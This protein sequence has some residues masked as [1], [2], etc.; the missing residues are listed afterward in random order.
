MAS[1]AKEKEQ[2]VKVGRYVVNLTNLD[3]IWFPESNISKGDI[4][5]YYRQIAPIMLSYIGDR[6]LT[7]KRF[8]EGIAKEGFFHKDAPTYF[9][10]W[11]KREA[12]KRSDGQIVNFVVCINEATLV[13]IAN[14]GCITPHIGLSRIDKL[15]Y[16]DKM[17]FDLDPS[18]D[19][20]SVVQD[21]AKALK[22]IF[23]ELQLPSFVMTTGS[24]GL[25]IVVPL[26][27]LYTFKRIRSFAKQI[28]QLLIARNSALF[29]M[30]IRKNKRNKKIFIDILR[31]ASRQTVVAPYAVRPLSTAPIA[32]PITW[33]E[34]Q[35]NRLSP[36]MYTIRT[37]FKRLNKVGDIWHD[38]SKYAVSIAK[39]ERKLKSL[40]KNNE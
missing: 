29:T 31:N 19:N 17:M 27:R 24:R 14:Y 4:V 36:T 13:Y 12:I 33:K 28:G 11:I 30:E 39:A 32:T 16:P 37:I 6:L 40:L 34:V 15:N 3:R 23:D 21:G 10:S 20:F 22:S 18:I 8:P 1:N 9:P 26:K 7:M 25:H 5:D 38:M 2:T 35:N